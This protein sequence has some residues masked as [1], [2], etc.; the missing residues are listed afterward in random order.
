MIYL[1]HARLK[2]KA[3]EALK[4]YESIIDEERQLFNRTQPQGVNTEKE[5][6]SGGSTA[7]AFDVYL[8]AKEKLKIDERL[9]EAKAIYNEHLELLKASEKTLK[10]SPDWFDI[11]YRL[12]YINKLT[13]TQI[14]NRLPYSRSQIWRKYNK[15]QQ[16]VRRIGGE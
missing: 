6:I 12:R 15:I 13:I 4:V 7:N 3:D 5:K 11:I 10:A 9:V 14:T 1:E 8:Q 16:N 2:K